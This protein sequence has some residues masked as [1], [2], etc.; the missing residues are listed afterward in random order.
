MGVDYYSHAAIGLRVPR[1][2]L[3]RT[4]EKSLCNHLKPKD[5]QFCPTCG[6]H[7]TEAT[8]IAIEGYDAGRDTFLGYHV[9]WGTD[10]EFAYI[11]LLH[12]A[13]DTSDGEHN[14]VALRDTTALNQ[15]AITCFI[16]HMT[17]AR[18][19]NQANFGLHVVF[20]IKMFD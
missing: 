3:F 4:E 10:S 2:T 11:C 18:I 8:E 14:M 19:W 5:A 17:G 12:C 9:E 7:V 1:E 6:K 13:S 16:N 15:A 20:V